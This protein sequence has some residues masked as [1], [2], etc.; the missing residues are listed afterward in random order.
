MEPDSRGAIRIREEVNHNAVLVDITLHAG[1]YLNLVS[2]LRQK[3]WI[4]R[5]IPT[6]DFSK[7]KS[8]VEPPH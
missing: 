5:I 3:A 8:G 4:R 6:E 1:D 7:R 2:Q